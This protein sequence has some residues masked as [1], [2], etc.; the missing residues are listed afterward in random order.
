MRRASVSYIAASADY[1]AS[2]AAR[3]AVLRIKASGVLVIGAIEPGVFELRGPEFN[4][5]GVLARALRR[6]CRF[7]D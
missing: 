7:H 4:E 1:R 3:S 6:E 5:C 2:A